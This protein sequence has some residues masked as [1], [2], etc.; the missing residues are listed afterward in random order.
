MGIVSRKRNNSI[1]TVCTLFAALILTGGVLAYNLIG[2]TASPAFAMG[3][4]HRSSLHMALSRHVRFQAGPAAKISSKATLQDYLRQEPDVDGKLKTAHTNAVSTQLSVPNPGPKSVTHTNNGFSGF[5]ALSH[6]DQRY[7]DNGNQFSLEPPDQGLC[8][9]NGF[10]LEEVNLAISIYSLSS[11][12]VVQ[13]GISSLNR[14]FGLP[15]AITRST[16]PVYGPFLSDPRCYY[17]HAT[18]R[19]FVSILEIDT[20]PTSGALLQNSSVLLAVSQTS[21]PTGGWSVFTLD[22]TDASTANC[23]C[24]GDQPLLGADA[25]GI[26]ISTNE[27]GIANAVFNGAIIYAISK[28]ALEVGTASS[29]VAFQVASALGSAGGPV[30]SV[31]PAISST[32]NGDN[33]HNNGTEYFLSALDFAGTLDNRLAVW[34]MTNTASLGTSTP[35]PTL[36]VTLINSETYGLPPAAKQRTG[37]TPLGTALN[38][39]LETI[40]SNDDRM[41][42]VFWAANYLWS[43]LNTIVQ[44]PGQKPRVGIA[45]FIIHPNASMNSISATIQRQGYIAV[46]NDSVIFPSVAASPSGSGIMTFTLVG[47]DY[48]PSVA[49]VKLNPTSA[50]SNVHVARDGAFPEDGFSGYQAYGGNGTARWGD[51]SA[52]FY[53]R[54]SGRVWIASEYI[55]NTQR[56]PLANWGTFIGAVDPAASA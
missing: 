39:P 7:A 34:A 35:S 2:H 48:Y 13:Y 8:S 10:V 25:Y 12:Q 4:I 33:T 29:A 30:Y 24:F 56:T 46:A 22:T 47:P 19:W 51:Y 45:Y 5:N 15:S 16:P 44:T 55:P 49:Y 3:P 53:D 14:F 54:D 11:G 43:G 42:Q 31:Q 37:P 40:D 28:Q 18:G 21:N 50:A 36:T 1:V 52:A 17:D 41:N 23:P 6:A 20:D 38:A 27:F 9:G 26:Y 32:G